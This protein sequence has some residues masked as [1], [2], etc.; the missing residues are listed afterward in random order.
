VQANGASLAEATAR[1]MPELKAKPLAAA[2][3]PLLLLLQMFG[4][5]A[6]PLLDAPLATLLHMLLAGEVCGG[7]VAICIV[8]FAPW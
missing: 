4:A 7:P 8:T 5:D 2:L 1:V 3:A 6:V